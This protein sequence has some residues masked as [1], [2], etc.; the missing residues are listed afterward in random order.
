MQAVLGATVALTLM[1]TSVGGTEAKRSAPFAHREDGATAAAPLCHDVRDYGARGDAA[2]DD[3]TAF[4][5]AA[6]AAAASGGRGCVYV[7]PV[8]AGLGY[9]ITGTVKLPVGVALIGTL[10]GMPVVPWMF[11][12][13]YDVNSTGGPRI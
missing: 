1:G 10:A 4:N 5:S 6:A 13:P 11:G 2:S 8:A 7:P 9:V 12:P 3:T